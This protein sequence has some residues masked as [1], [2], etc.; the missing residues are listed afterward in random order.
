MSSLR[1]HGAAFERGSQGRR[2]G[3]GGV[4]TNCFG[5]SPNRMVSAAVAASS[6]SFQ[7]NDRTEEEGGGLLLLFC[8]CTFQRRTQQERKVGP[9]SSAF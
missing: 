4:E 8:C 9:V 2:G 7:T 3:G 1:S 6:V 5:C